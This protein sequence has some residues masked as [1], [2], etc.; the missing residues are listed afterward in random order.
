M[1]SKRHLLLASL[2]A[3]SL[4]LASACTTGLSVN[5]NNTNQAG[6]APAASGN[7]NP[8]PAPAVRGEPT[9]KPPK[10]GKGNIQVT[11]TPP[12][13][14]VTLIPTDETSA[15]QPQVYG[16]TPIVIADLAPGEYRVQLA[17]KGYKNFSKDVKVTA[18]S[19]IKITGNM[20]K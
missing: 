5:G 13:A 2:T 14:G 15:S 4:A 7:A 17:M 20:Q 6:P 16:Q 11:S 18:N 3:C 8:A 19:I 9:V 10:P 12:G 1:S